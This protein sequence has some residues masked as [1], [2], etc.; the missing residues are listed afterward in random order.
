MSTTSN[1]RNLING[2]WSDTGSV[3]ESIDPS[4]GEVVGAYVSAG[5]AEAQAA[6][7]AAR[8]TFDTTV[9]PAIRPCDRG[10]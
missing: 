6:I 4:T 8:S 7:A 10:H 5:R 2:E 9:G 1:A 3:H